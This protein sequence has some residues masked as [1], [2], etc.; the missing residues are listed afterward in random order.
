MIS[1]TIAKL[2]L[3]QNQTFV[4][5]EFEQ[6]LPLANKET[7]LA[8]SQKEEGAVFKL[9]SNGVV[10]ARNEWVYDDLPDNLEKK[11]RYFGTLQSS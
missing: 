1:Q 6:L 11:V 10:T 5:L 9:F 7:K 4:R 8:K 2:I 3:T